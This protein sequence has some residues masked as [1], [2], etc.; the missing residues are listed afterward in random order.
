M[1][2][3]PA[4]LSVAGSDPSGGAGIQADLKTLAALGVYGMAAVTAVTVQNTEGVKYVHALPPGVV[5]DQIDAVMEDI[6]PDVVKVGMV[7]DAE[8]LG[9]LADAFGRHRPAFL[10]VDPVMVS[11]S[12][13]PLMQPGAEVLLKERLLP[14]THL[15]TPNLPE[16]ERLTGLRI[17][18][19]E[20]AERAARALR[21]MGVDA[22]LLK[23]GHARGETKAD[24]LVGRDGAR[25][26]A[27]PAVATRNS[28]GTGCTLASAIAAYVARGER[29]E[30]AVGL[31]KDYLT[32]ALLAGKDVATGHGCGPLNHGFG[33]EKMHIME[34]R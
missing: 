11:S 6:R 3:Y 31:A 29:L 15:L 28:H 16:A 8:T 25:R 13:C 10:I 5:G 32:R 9:A 14:I 34:D 18:T 23:G 21:A 26:Y 22:V 12:G 2:R 7:N 27:A 20:E 30:D 4:V 33:P 19:P 17:T 1:R 24:L